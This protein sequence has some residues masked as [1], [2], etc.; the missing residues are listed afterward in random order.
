MSVRTFLQ[1]V[2]VLTEPVNGV[3]GA[4]KDGQES[5]NDPVLDVD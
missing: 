5:V 4:L 3:D 1:R 2:Q